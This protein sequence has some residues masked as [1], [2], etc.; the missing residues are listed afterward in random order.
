MRRTAPRFLEAD[1]GTVRIHRTE[2]SI[3]DSS[4]QVGTWLAFHGGM[5]GGGPG[6]PFGIVMRVMAI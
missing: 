1:F 3:L 4:T 6:K 5:R 2:P